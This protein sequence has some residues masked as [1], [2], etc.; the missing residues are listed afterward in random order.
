M[1]A[2]K[3]PIPPAT[4]ADIEALA[5]NLSR[6]AD[7]LHERI[8]RA[9]RQR[10]PDPAAGT[11]PQDLAHG[12][13]Q[14]DAQA[15]FDQEVLLRQSANHLYVQAAVLAAAGQEA[16]RQELMEITATARD[17]LRRVARLQA[18]AGLTAG[19]VTLAGALAAG[20]P[21]QWPAAVRDVRDRFKAL[22]DPGQA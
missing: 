16:V 14:Q 13:T 19:L 10:Q 18:L 20:K 6:C 22:H 3:P 12:I 8:M 15:L 9:I 4:P 2:T 17:E 1:N 5:D 21:A 11:P 7:A